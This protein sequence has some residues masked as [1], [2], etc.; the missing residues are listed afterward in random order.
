MN[1]D[2]LSS[3]NLL[4]YVIL[5]LAILVGYLR[6]MK[7]TLFAFISMLFFY[8]IFFLTINQVTQFLWTLEMPWL[9]NALGNID[10]SLSTFTSFQNSIGDLLQFALGDTV[11]VGSQSQ[12]LLDLGVGLGMFVVKL[13][14]T[15]LYFTVGLLIWKLL[16]FIIRLIILKKPQKGESKNRLFGAVFGALNGVMAVF[17]ALIMLGGLMSV[18]E[19]MITLVD[20]TGNNDIQLAVPNR[21]ETYQAS[22]S[23]IYLADENPTNSLD[24][25]NASLKKMVD[26]YNANFLVKIANQITV[27]NPDTQETIPLH[28][29]LFDSV[30]SFEYQEKT[31]AI[32]YELAVFSQ[33]LSVF[34]ESEYATTEVLSDITGDEIREVFEILSHSELI[35]S[36]LPVVIQV[37]ADHF[38]QTLP[39]TET[40]LFAIDYE[41]ELANLGNIAGTLFDILNGAGVISGDGGVQDIEVDAELVRE[42]FGDLGSSSIV[43]LLTETL[44]VP[45]ISNQETGISLIITIPDEID[46]E[47]EYIAI[48]EVLAEVVDADISFQDLEAGDPQLFLSA[49]S[50]VDLTVL[51]GSKIITNALV[52]ILSGATDIELP[53]IFVIPSNVQWYDTVDEFG[54]VTENGELRNI[55]LALNA[56]TGALGEVDFN[57]F[58]LETISQMDDQTIDALF[59]SRVLV[60]SVSDL[61]FSQDLGGTLLVIPDEVFDS[62]GYLTKAELKAFAKSILLVVDDNITSSGFDI[63]QIMTLTSTDIDTLLSSKII[64]ATIGNLIFELEN[65]QLLIPSEV[66]SSFLVNE[67]SVSVVN[68]TELKAFIQAIQSLNITDFNTIDLEDTSLLLGNISELVP[69]KI[70]HASISNFILSIASGVISIPEE[71]I[72]SSPILVTVSETT[73]IVESELTSLIAALDVLGIS[74]PTTFSNSFTLAAFELEA[75]QDIL[76]SSAIMHATISKTMLDLGDQVLLIPET[77]EDGV[78]ALKVTTGPVES[79]TTYVVKEEIKAIINALIAM[80][81]TDLSSFGTEISSTLFFAERNTILL[82]SSFQATLSDKILSVSSGQ[83]IVPDFDDALNPI[84][85]QVGDTLYIQLDELSNLLTALEAMGLTDLATFD[86]TPSALFQSDFNVVLTSYSM[87]ATI[88]KYLLDQALDESAPVGSTSLIVPNVFR[89]TILVEGLN[90]SQIN[91]VELIRMLDGLELLNITNFADPMDASI[92]TNLTTTELNTLFESGSMHV[93]TD[94][95][96]RGNTNISSQ[97]PSL[98]ETSLYGVTPITTV[99]ELVTFI[100]VSTILTNSTGDFTN[101]QIDYTFIASLTPSERDLVLDSMI[102]RNAMTIQL[103]AMMLADPLPYWPDNADYEESNPA[104]FLTESGI[105]NVLTFYGLI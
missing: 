84:R 7:K 27:T 58:G 76:L 90:A 23:V 104:Y 6:G 33:V 17:V 75:D 25:M 64:Q 56:L 74:N 30:L 73:Y 43:V 89:E 95:M 65:D 12:A 78:T 15:F 67:V 63:Q 1:L 98:A 85:N 72:N 53:S 94:N 40:E 18:A 11:N 10:P 101:A 80:N 29:N 13:L 96:L 8:L 42:V 71:D 91:K 39:I 83:L 68:K 69:S 36:I 66:T 3:I 81:F 70:I 86:V 60:A 41:T 87:Q 51:M 100:K 99:S 4:F 16:M 92:I 54:V 21:Y 19:S 50:K 105:N 20:A 55:L 32:R 9:G 45:M 57:N 37:G 103:E 22:Q 102:V 28:L 48:G 97:I 35:T 34:L 44:L 61:L 77:K 49:A 5:G 38:E 79:Q 2:F 26:E 24:E 31:I 93:T 82:S 47:T 14:Y 62:E 46:W 52:N 59:E 88:S